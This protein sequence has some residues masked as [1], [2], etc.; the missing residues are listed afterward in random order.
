MNKA[1]AMTVTLLIG[2]ALMIY[3]ASRTLALLQMTLPAGQGDLAFLALAAFDGGL[4]GWTLTFM[5]GAEGSWQRAIAAMMIAVCLVGVIVGFGADSILGALNGGVVARGTVDGNFGLTV[6]L[7][8]VA[9]IALNIAATVGFHVMSP[10]NRRRMQEETFSDHIEAAA[11]K[12][13][14]EAIPILAAQLAE[15]LT[16][17][18]MAGLNAKYQSMMVTDQRRLPSLSSAMITTNRPRR[19][20]ASRPAVEPSRLDKIKERLSAVV[21]PQHDGM[22]TLASES[23]TGDSRL[24]D[25]GAH[26]K[27]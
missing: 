24:E 14:G 9:I 20:I 19:Q 3:S 2:L 4:I 17:S 10:A 22:A 7:A 25:V 16:A 5:F 13:S 11:F 26:P 12:K 21:A 6:V 1:I 18:R 27:S 8:T 23:D 15:Q